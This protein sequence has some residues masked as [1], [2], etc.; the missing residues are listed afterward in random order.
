MDISQVQIT[1]ALT[2]RH[3]TSR[4][5]QTLDYLVPEP[6]MGLPANQGL[7]ARCEQARAVCGATAAGISMFGTS[8]FDNLVWLVVV[9]DL[10]SY[11]GEAFPRQD[12]PCG[13]C[14]DYR[15]TQLFQHPERYFKWMTAAGVA[16]DELLV[17][18]IQG[19]YASF[20]GTLWVTGGDKAQ[21]AFN[22]AHAQM[23]EKLTVGIWSRLNQHHAAP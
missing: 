5:W 10:S 3:A 4:D 1:Q 7:T 17:A 20:F 16:I 23:M 15:S 11:Q 13:V 12:S 6:I 2:Q 8:S 22:L 19:P 14:F 18:P 9:G 21:G